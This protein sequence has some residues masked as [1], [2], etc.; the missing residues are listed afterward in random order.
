MKLCEFAKKQT[1]LFCIM[2]CVVFLGLILALDILCMNVF[3]DVYPYIVSMG[4]ELIVTIAAVILLFVSGQITV[5]NRKGLGVGRGLLSGLYFLIISVIAILS[6]LF[7]AAH[8]GKT[9]QPFYLI[10]VFAVYM[11]CIGLAEEFIFR[12]IIAD[13]LL[14]KFGTSK[15]GIW[16]AVFVS[17]ILFGLAH[18]VNILVSDIEGVLV[19]VVIASM[20]GMVFAAIYYRCGNIWAVVMIHILNDFAADIT[21]GLFGGGTLTDSISEYSPVKLIAC[22]PYIIILFILL[23]KKK[24]GSIADNMKI[25]SVTK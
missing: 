3:T 25:K 2:V 19:Q 22:I 14:K 20:M 6:N 1:I 8:E 7:L 13:L 24:I 17:G 10:A 18:L 23:R 5:L 9:L 16:M 11:I 15:S 4:T 12:G 21:N